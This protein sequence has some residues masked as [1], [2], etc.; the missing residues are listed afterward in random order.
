MTVIK[1]W[2]ELGEMNM[3]QIHMMIMIMER[4]ITITQKMKITMT[5]IM[6]KVELKT[7]NFI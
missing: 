3:K 1:V 7:I 2:V 4:M 6:A 5:M